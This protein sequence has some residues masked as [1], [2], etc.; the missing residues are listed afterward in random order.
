M[1]QKLPSADDLK[2]WSTSRLLITLNQICLLDNLGSGK[3][4]VEEFKSATPAQ[5]DAFLTALC[6][7]IDMRVPHRGG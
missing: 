5:L 6:A 1:P 3:I 4:K 7:E 2:Q